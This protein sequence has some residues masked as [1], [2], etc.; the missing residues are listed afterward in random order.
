M[1]FPISRNRIDAITGG[2]ELSPGKWP[3]QAPELAAVWGSASGACRSMN[4]VL[5]S[6]GRVA[7]IQM[8]GKHESANCDCGGGI[9]HGG[10]SDSSRGALAGYDAAYAE[11]DQ[12]DGG[13]DRGAFQRCDPIGE[14]AVFGGAAGVGSQDR[15]S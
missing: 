12:A 3:E 8:E 11:G 4:W 9:D 7:D 13:T 15:E 10:N 5:N 14:Y 1:E 2:V 6:R